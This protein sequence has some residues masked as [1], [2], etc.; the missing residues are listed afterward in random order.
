MFAHVLQDGLEPNVKQVKSSMEL[1]TNNCHKLFLDINE[2]NGDHE[3]DHSCTNVDGSFICSCD[4]GYQLQS[5]RR[6][7]EGFIVLLV[8]GCIIQK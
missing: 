6:T 5:D 8:T 7:C 2:C 1:L 3:C 4:P